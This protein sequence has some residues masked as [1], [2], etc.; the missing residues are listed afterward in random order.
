MCDLLWSDPQYINGRSESKRGVGIQF[1]PGYFIN[2]T[3]YLGRCYNNNLS[4][5]IFLLLFKKYL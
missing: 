1:G 5:F 4:G 2:F 3:M